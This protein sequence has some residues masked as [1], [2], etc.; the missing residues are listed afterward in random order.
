MMS[1]LP[2]PVLAVECHQR[3]AVLGEDHRRVARGRR[4][5]ADPR[6]GAVGED[7]GVVGPGSGWVA[8][9]RGLRDE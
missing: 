1:K 9:G 3:A 6:P 7:V 4:G 5:P 2:Y 8:I